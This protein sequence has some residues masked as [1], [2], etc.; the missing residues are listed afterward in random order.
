MHSDGDFLGLVALLDPLKFI[1]S[2]S[3]LTSFVAA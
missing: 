2:M 3:L 1:S